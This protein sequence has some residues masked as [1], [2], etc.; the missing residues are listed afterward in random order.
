[1]ADVAAKE[2]DGVL[3]KTSLFG[4]PLEYTKT[5][6][7]ID[8]AMVAGG[9]MFAGVGAAPA[10]G[11]AAARSGVMMLGR[12][13]LRSVFKTAAK[14]GVEAAAKTTA[15]VA[16]EAGAK[17]AVKETAEA[18]AKKG[19]VDWVAPELSKGAAEFA[20]KKAAERTAREAAEAT[21]KAAAKEG[22]EATAKAATGAAAKEAT[23]EA[24]ESTSKSLLGVAAKA[25]SYAWTGAKIVAAP[26]AYPKTFIL[27]A[28]AGHVLT[29]GLTSSMIWGG[30]TGLWN[31]GKEYVPGATSAIAEAGLKLGDGTMGFLKTGAQMGAQGLREYLPAGLVPAPLRAALGASDASVSRDAQ[32]SGPAAPTLR[33]RANAAASGVRER[34]TDAAENIDFMDTPEAGP[35]REMIANQ[36]NMDPAKVTGK[37]LTRKLGQLAKDNPYFGIGMAFGALYGGMGADKNP[38][39]R[40]MGAAMYGAIFG[41]A[42]QFLGQIYPGLLPGMMKMLSGAPDALAKVPGAIGLNTSSLNGGFR[43]AAEGTTAAPTSSAPATSPSTP[44]ASQFAQA[45]S[46]KPAPAPAPV[47]EDVDLRRNRPEAANNAAYRL[48]VGA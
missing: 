31:L 20:A 39:Q 28:S 16:V 26:I 47:P 32:Q 5:D 15:K 4:I 24:V 14:E 41:F 38:A 37:E 36:L 19:T 18:A 46:G 11:L 9:A 8:G 33:D 7:A 48:T 10:A 29:G 13:I 17:T 30:Y 44:T 12:G 22:T 42:F 6:A 1:M 40:A 43:S 23:K 25:G 21:A 35:F 45:A 2:D 34:V 27:G 3:F